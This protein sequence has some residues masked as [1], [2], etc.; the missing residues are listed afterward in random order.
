MPYELRLNV[1]RD[2]I[3]YFAHWLGPW[4]CFS[5]YVS[6]LQSSMGRLDLRQHLSSG[7]REQAIA[8]AEDYAY[9]VIDGVA[10]LSISGVMMKQHTSYGGGTSTVLVRRL[11]SKAMNDPQVRAIAFKLDTP[12]GTVAGTQELAD[13]IAAAGQTKRT[14]AFC[15]DLTASAGYWIASQC[16]SIWANEMASVGS[17]GTY[18]VVADTSKAYADAGVV[19]HVVR[20]G[21]FKGAMTEGTPITEEQLSEAQRL[22]DGINAKFLET[23]SKGRGMSLDKVAALADGRVH[24]AKEAKAM[25]L[26]DHVGS[27]ESAFQAFI[28]SL[29]SSVTSPATVPASQPSAQETTMSN[30]AKPATAADLRAALPRAGADFILSCLEASMTLQEAQA[31]YM[32]HLVAK[33]EAAALRGAGVKPARNGRRY[34]AEDM[35]YDGEEDKKKMPV[36]EDEVPMPEE[37]ED[38]EEMQEED[39]PMAWR[40]AVDREMKLCG[41]DRHRAVA[42]ANR[43]NPG[44]RKR[45]LQA[46]NARAG[47]RSII[48]R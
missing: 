25:G 31:A 18:C 48:V 22:V 35:K 20:A 6:G 11:L 43:K 40:R 26:V 38:E 34:R 29:D 19:I 15:S 3:P 45:Y 14:M 16:G 36:M 33:T 13:D 21:A 32:S 37:E 17:I 5:D 39:A 9:S 28:E 12:G 10:V 24:L 2:E 1:Q 42:N 7:S 30:E 4:A 44:L 41:G 46:V 27:W 47:R 8:E 23:V